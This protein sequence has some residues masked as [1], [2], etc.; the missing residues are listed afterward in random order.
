[1]QSHRRIA[2]VTHSLGSGG[3]DSVVRF[4]YKTLTES[5]RYHPEIISLATSSSD[6]ASVLLRKVGTWGRGALVET[7]EER[8]LPYR[9]I[10]TYGAELEFMRY[11][12]RS[13]LTRILAEYDL[14]QVV[15]GT[16]AWGNVI[17]RV[18]VPV[19]LQVATLAGSERK[20]L[21]ANGSPMLRAWRT[22]M[23]VAN[24]PIETQALCRMD[25][26]FVENRWMYAFVRAKTRPSCAVLFAP[27]GVDTEVFCPKACNS[28]SIDYILSVGRFADPRKNLSL[29][30]HAYT[31]LRRRCQHPPRLVL[32]GAFELSRTD[33]GLMEEQGIVDYVDIRLRPSTEELAELYRHAR[34]FVMPS[35][36]EGLGIAVLEAM[37]SG[38]PI[39][40]TR[41]G[42]VETAV[43]DGKN[44][45]LTPVGEI[46]GLS[47]AMGRILEDG[48]LSRHIGEAARRTALEQFSMRATGTVFLNEYDQ[49]LAVGSRSRVPLIHNAGGA[50]VSPS[51]GS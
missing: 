3:V 42:G 39:V 17:G 29:L 5:G 44:G 47:D 10:G 49:L 46:V 35:N 4:L 38:V 9:H 34:L 51:G 2:I 31:R 1:M 20:T 23:T 50:D 30:L 28:V 13:I 43:I 21:L 36:E 40:S 32:A 12:P 25:C 19:C 37:A 14:I 6:A 41:N 18:N 24:R 11:Q 7:H 26:V 27:P 33:E 15:A 48:E 22:A 16:P 8:G 45:L